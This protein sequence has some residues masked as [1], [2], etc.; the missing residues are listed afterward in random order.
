MGT[1]PSKPVSTPSRP[2]QAGRKSCFQISLLGV[3]AKSRSNRNKL[4]EL[5]ANHEW[6]KV[7]IRASLFPS[8]ISQVSKFELYG[9][10]WTLLPIH[11]ACALNPPPEVI[12]VLLKDHDDDA[13]VLM[14]RAE[15]ENKKRRLVR[16]KKTVAMR[17]SKR[18]GKRSFLLPSSAKELPVVLQS[19]SAQTLTTNDTDD[20]DDSLGSQLA[21]TESSRGST[22]DLPQS[23]SFDM[24]DGVRPAL[25]L[26][27]A[28]DSFDEQEEELL[29]PA[30][31]TGAQTSPIAQGTPQHRVS[32]SLSGISP[33]P[34]SPSLDPVSSDGNASVASSSC[35]GAADSVSP[36]LQFMPSGGV[37]N[38]VRNYG[39]DDMWVNPERYVDSFHRNPSSDEQ[40]DDYTKLTEDDDTYS[41]L[42]QVADE[43]NSLIEDDYMS[44]LL[45][46]VAD[47]VISPIEDD[48]MSSL[49]SQVTDEVI[50]CLADN[51]ALH[52]ATLGGVS[53][54]PPES[55]ATVQSNPA[56]SE[57][58]SK[59]QRPKKTRSLVPVWA[60]ANDL[61]PLHIACL[62]RA[63]PLIL[64]RLVKANP[65][66][67][68]SFNRTFGLLPIHILS[69]GFSVDAPIQ[70][71]PLPPHLSIAQDST[72]EKWDVV[73]AIE[74][75]VE[76]CPESRHTVSRHDGLI[77]LT[78]VEE[79]M[80]DGPE[81][82]LVVHLL[83]DPESQNT[84]GLRDGL[85]LLRGPESQNSAG[86]RDGLN[87]FRSPERRSPFSDQVG[88]NPLTFVE[89]RM[90]ENALVVH[91]VPERRQLAL[92]P[93]PIQS[94]K[95]N[96]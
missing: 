32:M 96:E 78:Y 73:K 75:L 93:S 94:P 63:S 34:G 43:V 74:T 76:A 66:A 83:R 12:E 2:F 77:P 72:A 69:A 67:L 53:L 39:I 80:G 62:F 36:G 37:A 70:P 71:P 57:A 41:S 54:L 10:K 89:D 85:S 28:S 40:A 33:K 35:L 55:V 22:Q 44:S 23:E 27:D 68:L 48:D 65:K 4:L 18:G 15:S 45:S 47:E 17:P 30:N 51:V 1:K 29:L 11:L 25:L 86:L 16:K 87:L 49:L 9:I 81:K 31:Q 7:L 46:Q 3:K 8:E 90:P 84:V 56:E 38:W 61:L 14:T 91:F 24:H 58:A 52:F 64:Q 19:P 92:M 21:L 5:I 20:E 50:S 82:A 88:T 60:R 42:S 26:G 79:C 13:G 59:V 6:Q 95:G